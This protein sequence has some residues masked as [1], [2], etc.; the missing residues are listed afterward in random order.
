[1]HIFE[2]SLVPSPTHM[3]L[4]ANHWRKLT[5]LWQ[6]CTNETDWP[7]DRPTDWLTDW[8]SDWLTDWLIGWP[9]HWLIDSLTHSIHTSLIHY[10]THYLTHSLAI[11]IP[12]THLFT[13]E[14]IH[15]FIR[16]PPNRFHWRVPTAT[17]LR[18][19]LLLW[20]VDVHKSRIAVAMCVRDTWW[21]HQMETF[22]ALLAICAGNS[23]VPVNS[24]HKDQRRRALMFTLICARINGWVNNR[25]AGDFRC[26]STHSDV[27]VMYSRVDHG[28][29]VQ[30]TAL[31]D[32]EK[33]F[34]LFE[35]KSMPVYLSGLVWGPDGVSLQM[36]T[37]QS[38]AC[39]ISFSFFQIENNIRHSY[40][41]ATW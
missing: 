35:E 24:P 33:H 6:T 7:T 1:M 38:N 23:P 12:L 37:V 32:N 4:K 25:E 17:D 28:L 13:H 16:S 40:A 3:L 39:G 31:R 36:V 27:T 2:L 20:N 5:F 18:N 26:H 29:I 34:R 8:L 14:F 15:S 11:H 19:Y 22:S 30:Q 41:N 9:T 21:R 10:L